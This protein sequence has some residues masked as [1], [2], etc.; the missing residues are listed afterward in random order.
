M[1]I[2]LYKPALRD[3]WFRQQMLADE[4]TM[5]YNR[6]WGGTIQFPEEAWETW[7]A[8]WV[9]DGTGRHFYRYV[10]NEAGEFVGEVAY[11]YSEPLGGHVANVIVYAPFRGRGC[12]SAAL[13]ALC[14]AAK[15]N[16]IA[17][18][19]DDI[20]VGNP[21]IGMFLRHGFTEQSRTDDVII[22]KKEL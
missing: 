19:Y 22:L 8:R 7:Y 3:L 17:V 5:S 16:G 1:K 4:Q 6:A 21:A 15:E 13:D 12:G 10:L 14:A 9:C 11:H 2:N 18:L 20:A